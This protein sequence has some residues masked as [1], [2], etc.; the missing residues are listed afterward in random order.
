MGWFCI[1]K[2]LKEFFADWQIFRTEFRLFR[3][4]ALTNLKENSNTMSEQVEQIKA[5]LEAAKQQIVSAVETL[6]VKVDELQQKVSEGGNAVDALREIKE[7]VD[8]FKSQ[9]TDGLQAKVNE[10]LAEPAAPVEPPPV[11]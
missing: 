4:E 8:A 3:R 6:G 7:H 5:T 10:F 11:E 2:E 1:R 9:V